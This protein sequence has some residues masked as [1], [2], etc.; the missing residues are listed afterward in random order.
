M[1]MM[2]EI[3]SAFNLPLK[4]F[5]TKSFGNGLINQ[6]WRIKNSQDDFIL[7]K[8]NEKVFKHPETI[9]SNIRRLSDYLSVTDP[10]FLFTVPLK[11]K[12]NE[13]M[14]YISGKGYFRLTRYVKGS[15]TIAG[16]RGRKR[17]LKNPDQGRIFYG[18]PAGLYE[19]NGS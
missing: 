3:F 2:E 4:E 17:F 19:R 8:I 13:D 9:A 16:K 11:T 15:H 6:T 12:N 5:E 1:S 10:G 14:A 18:N 7:Q